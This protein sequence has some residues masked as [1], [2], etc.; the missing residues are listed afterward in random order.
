MTRI[1]LFYFLSLK[2]NEIKSIK[3]RNIQL[4][5]SLFITLPLPFFAVIA[6]AATS[7]ELQQLDQ[8]QINQQQINQQ[9]RQRAQERQLSP[10]SPDVRLQEPGAFLTRLHF[11]VEMTPCFPIKKVELQGTE[12]FPSWL[13]LQRL[14]DQAVNQCLGGKGINLLMSALQN[15]LVNHGYVTARVLAPAQD[16]KSGT[17]KLVVMAGKVGKITL[18]PDSDRYVQLYSAM[19]ARESELL[20]LRDIEQGL[21]N[22]QRVPTAQAGMT[23]SGYD[24]HQTIAGL[25]ENYT[26]SGENESLNF[27][28]SRVLHRSGSQKTSVSYEVMTRESR[29]FINDT[30]V[31]VQRRKT[32]GW[33]LGLQH[34]HY[35][36]QA[37][38][39]AAVS[40]QRGT[41]W[42]GAQPIPEE[43]NDEGTGLSKI[44]QFSSELDVPFTV[45][46][47]AFRYNV[48]YRRQLANTRLTAQDQFSI[49]NRWTVRGFDGELTLSADDGWLVRNELAWR[50][51]LQNQE[52]YLGVDY[53]EV[54]NN[55]KDRLMGNHLAGGVVGLRGN[56][57]NTGYDLFA[58][59]PLSKPDGFETS[60]A[61]FGFSLSWQY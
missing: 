27:Q 23:A 53:G 55:S 38:L 1:V 20:D 47:E 32:A 26:Y 29:N 18:S 43:A 58:G 50:T 56:V 14:A 11:P 57:L 42:F 31:E 28:L 6:N 59:I 16:L 17:L 48:Q 40:Y 5:R 49:G 60:P 24:Y 51:P 36:S 54:S 41:R 10:Q 22:L 61:V 7:A 13:P 25:N 34:R 52:L 9:E 44:I 33:R 30:E 8:R 2:I 21:E 3:L 39:D 45:F 37:T 4:I 12:D 19:P 15:R 46:D 35:I